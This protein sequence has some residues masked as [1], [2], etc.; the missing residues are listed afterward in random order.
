MSRVSL[1]ISTLS[2]IVIADSTISQELILEL[3]FENFKRG[4]QGAEFAALHSQLCGHH[5]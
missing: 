1:K 3:I 4:A 5:V 2:Y